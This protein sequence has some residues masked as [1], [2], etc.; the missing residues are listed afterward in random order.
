MNTTFVPLTQVIQVYQAKAAVRA[1]AGLRPLIGQCEI[2]RGGHC[3]ALFI[4]DL[5]EHGLFT[6]LKNYFT[7]CPKGFFVALK[8]LVFAL[9]LALGLAGWDPN[10][11][12]CF[13]GSPAQCP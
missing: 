3:S 9:F 6:A 8:G 1:A 5:R 11:E 4:N 10:E 13:E 2:Q 12:P 7:K